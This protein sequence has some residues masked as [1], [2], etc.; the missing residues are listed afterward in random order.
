[1][2]TQE[3]AFIGLG[4][5][6]SSP[7]QQLLSAL[8]EIAVTPGITLCGRS[9]L[10]RSAPVGFADQPNFI[11]AVAEV[12]TALTPI[13]LL[14]ELLAIERCHGRVRD[15]P[16]APRT[17]DLDILIYGDLQLASPALTLPHPR[18]HLRGFVLWPLFELA[19]D[20]HIPGRGSVRA[21]LAQNREQ[22]I[23][24][25]ADVTTVRLALGSLVGAW[26]NVQDAEPG[27]VN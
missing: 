24:R 16:N 22:S 12:R 5:N 15:F 1:M 8:D 10:Y 3:R 2:T 9:S 6:L 20:A 4:S 27:R 19:P 21:L 26:V 11:N 18:A 23:A 7:E 13:E 25:I 14:D 17:L